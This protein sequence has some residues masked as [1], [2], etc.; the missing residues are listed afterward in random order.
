MGGV[1][2]GE[3]VG[4]T[5]R[6]EVEWDR[7]CMELELELACVGSELDDGVFKVSS[8]AGV[9][10]TAPSLSLAGSWWDS[11][12]KWEGRLFIVVGVGWA[13]GVA[14]LDLCLDPEGG[15]EGGAEG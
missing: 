6:S 7:E 12:F 11:D 9:G 4:V 10:A 14:F 13:V 3:E 2:R 5:K 1:R 15:V 8:A